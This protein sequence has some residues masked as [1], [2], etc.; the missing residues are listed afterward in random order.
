[1]RIPEISVDLEVAGAG[2]GGMKSSRVCAFMLDKLPGK[3]VIDRVD[4]LPPYAE[5]ACPCT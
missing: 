1:M 5:A 3:G 4:I 2:G